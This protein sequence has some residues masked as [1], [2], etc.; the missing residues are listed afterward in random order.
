MENSTEPNSVGH[1]PVS[2]KQQV[3]LY[4]HF[5]KFIIA[6][7]FVSLAISLLYLRYAKKSYY[8]QGMVILQDER[9]VEKWLVWQNWPTWQVGPL[10]LQPT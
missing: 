3:D 1:G 4:L 10:H 8:A 9:Q 6:F 2:L 7:L 5:W